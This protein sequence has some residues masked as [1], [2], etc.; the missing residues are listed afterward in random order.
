VV[1]LG[2]ADASDSVLIATVTSDAP[3][4]FP[5][6]ETVITWTATDSSGNNSTATQKITLVDTTAPVIVAPQDLTFEATSASDNMVSITV[7]DATDSVS[8]VNISSDAPSTFALGQTTVTWTATDEAG[9][10]ST[11]TQKITVVDTTAPNLSIP[12][13]IVIDAVSL[14]TPVTVGTPTATDL[15]DDLPK[16]TSDAPN[17]FPLGQTLVTW[18]AEDKFGNSVTHTQTVTV[19][20]CGK[21]ESAYNKIVG[22]EDDDILIGTNLADLIITLGGD[23]IISGEKGNDCILA[24][25]GDDII[26]GNEGNDMI[27]GGDGADILKGQSGNDVLISST[28]VDIIDGGDDNDSCIVSEQDGDITI[29]CE[30]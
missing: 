21:P 5:L 18:F 19:E 4:K 26:Y 28:G 15:T 24:G 14:M 17:S 3:D 20:A 13:N 7:P 11:A 22:E 9:N 27:N 6:G 8:A 10:V 12:E 29:K 30:S 25:D 16:I 1:S 23:D 2:T